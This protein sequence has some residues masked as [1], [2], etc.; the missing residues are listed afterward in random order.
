MRAFHWRQTA[1]RSSGAV[2]AQTLQDKRTVSPGPLGCRRIC[3]VIV[4]LFEGRLP[5]PDNQRM[6]P[7][8]SKAHGLR[9]WTDP[10]RTRRCFAMAV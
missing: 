2:G 9:H 8:A 10:Y 7:T 4:S 5:P 6:T 3:P 1:C